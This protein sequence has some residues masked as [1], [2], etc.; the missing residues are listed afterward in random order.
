M[1]ILKKYGLHHALP[2]F[3]LSWAAC[4]LFSPII[5]QGV[6][7]VGAGYYGGREENQAEARGF[8]P[9]SPCTWKMSHFEFKDF[10]TVWILV[11]F[12]VWIMRGM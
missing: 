9:F 4:F 7:L 11:T 8:K 1:E 5:G 6:A 10:L 3:I 12:N 2:V